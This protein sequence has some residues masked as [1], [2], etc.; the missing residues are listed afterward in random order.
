M[1]RGDSAKAAGMP[2]PQRR[3][4]AGW[5]SALAGPRPAEGGRRNPPGNAACR[6]TAVAPASHPRTGAMC[7]RPS[8]QAHTCQPPP[9]RRSGPRR[10]LS[11]VSRF[12]TGAWSA[13]GVRYPPAPVRGP[14]NRALLRASRRGPWA[15]ASIPVANWARFRASRPPA[16]GH[17]GGR[18]PSVGIVIGWLLRWRP[19]P[20]LS[21]LRD[22]TAA[23]GGRLAR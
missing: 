7:T 3:C 10:W 13:P 9:I 17:P 8:A 20:R 16:A 5:E 2:G 4:Q 19:Y 12:S 6:S 1:S 11:L 15:V 14:T 23:P 18:V 22:L 21:V